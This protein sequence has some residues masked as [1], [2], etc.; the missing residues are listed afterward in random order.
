MT[1]TTDRLI[2]IQTQIAI[3]KKYADE[4]PDLLT[5]PLVLENLLL[6]EKALIEQLKWEAK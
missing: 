2:K 4:N 6:R 3:A 5:P 1:T